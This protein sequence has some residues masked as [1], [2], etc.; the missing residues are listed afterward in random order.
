MNFDFSAR[1]RPRTINI[2][3]WGRGNAPDRGEVVLN[4]CLQQEAHGSLEMPWSLDSIPWNARRTDGRPEPSA[5]LQQNTQ[6]RGLFSHS[7]W[8]RVVG[9]E[10][11]T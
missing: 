8:L 1:G 11:D 5:E 10:N 6:P 2:E 3:I 7:A 9:R 4:L